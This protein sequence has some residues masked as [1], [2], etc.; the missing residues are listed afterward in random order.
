MPTLFKVFF[1]GIKQLIN[2]I[3]YDFLFVC[4]RGSVY[5]CFRSS[6]FGRPVSMNPTFKT[7]VYTNPTF[8][9][10]A[11]IRKCASQARTRDEDF[12]FNFGR[13][14]WEDDDDDDD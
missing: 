6:T 10:V 11:Q 14:D 4:F 9:G 8:Q 1:I 3:T 12:K 5:G 2:S 13:Q 7:P